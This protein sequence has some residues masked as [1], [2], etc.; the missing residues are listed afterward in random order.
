[1]LPQR[2]PEDHPESAARRSGQ[3]QTMGRIM[4][5]LHHPESWA[6][7][8]RR[9]ATEPNQSRPL[10]R[11]AVSTAPKARHPANPAHTRSKSP[12][13]TGQL[14][15]Q[16]PRRSPLNPCLR[17]WCRP[18]CKP[19]TILRRSTGLR[20]PPLQ[21]RPSRHLLSLAVDRASIPIARP[22][23]HPIGPPHQADSSSSAANDVIL[24]HPAMSRGAGPPGD[25]CRSTRLRHRPADPSDPDARWCCRQCR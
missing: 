22:A 11:A 16:R 3:D 8:M 21:I 15:Q 4:A 10:I 17:R 18:G 5:L 20:Q 14:A 6:R 2:L 1:M 23:P 24:I 7:M 19:A 9:K 25:A 13:A 12:P